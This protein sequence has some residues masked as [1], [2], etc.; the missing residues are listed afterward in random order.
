MLGL[1][2]ERER[3]KSLEN[4]SEE[5]ESCRAVWEFLP[6]IVGPLRPAKEFSQFY[7]ESKVQEH[8]EACA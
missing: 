4:P 5:A 3:L 6:R 8:T 7:A 2:L 1:A